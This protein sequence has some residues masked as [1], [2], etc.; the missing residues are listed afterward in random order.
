M[1]LKRADLTYLPEILE[2][3]AK[4]LADCARICYASSGDN[5]NALYNNL[6]KNGHRSCYRHLS[7]YFIIPVADV[8][9]DYEFGNMV[10]NFFNIPYISIASNKIN[11]YISTNEQFIREHPVVYSAIID[12]EVAPIVAHRTDEFI[13]S[14][15][16]R[17]SFVISTGIDITRELNR[18]SPNNICEQSTRYVDFNKKIG[19]CFKKSHWMHK[20]DA[21]SLYKKLLYKF[22]CK[23]DEWFYKISRSKYGLNLKPEDARWCLFLDT[24]SKA[25]YTYSFNEWKHIIDLRY[26]GTTGKPHPDAYAIGKA[27]YDWF[28]LTGYKDKL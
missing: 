28:Y 23:V 15:V 21:T 19:I 25:V 22:M 18:V 12:Y 6:W 17:Y 4:H 14:G 24:C 11:Y 26:H 27:L 7:H 3:K 5:D 1:K 10:R 13:Q 20:V 2:T 9:A 16:L 8:K